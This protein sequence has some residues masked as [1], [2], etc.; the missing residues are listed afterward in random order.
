[1]AGS[2]LPSRT[3]ALRNDN[4][5]MADN[6]IRASTTNDGY[7]VPQLFYTKLTSMMKQYDR[8]FDEQVVTKI[9]TATGAPMP[10]PLL[11]DTSAVATQINE[12]VISV[13][14]TPDLVFGQLGLPQALAWRSG[15]ITIPNQLFQDSGVPVEDLLVNSFGIRFGRGIGAANVTTL[16]AAAQL[17]A[18]AQGD[19]NTNNATG[20]NSLGIDDLLSLMG[21][22]D[23][24]YVNSPKCWWAMSNSTLIAIFKLK[25]KQGRYLLH[26]SRDDNGELLLFDKRVAICPSLANIGTSGSPLVGNIPVLFGDFSRFVVR[27]VKDS[28]GLIRA[29]EAKGLA[30]NNCMAFQMALRTNAGLLLQSGSDSPIKYLQNATS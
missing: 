26:V 9:E 6:F 18:T 7:I 22:I 1:M 14:D 12:N 28:W 19:P 13:K 29:R 21:S 5:L 20:A 27:T 4:S 25:D 10:F 2:F 8:L 11:D 24:S 23:P 3:A 16:L 30:E 15:Y 17:G